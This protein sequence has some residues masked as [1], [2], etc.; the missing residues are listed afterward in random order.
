MKSLLLFVVELFVCL[1]V[2]ADVVYFV[3]TDGNCDEL[4]M[5]YIRIKLFSLLIYLIKDVILMIPPYGAM[6][7]FPIEP[8]M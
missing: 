6:A 1:H 2:H 4:G 3:D 8:M 7:K 5:E